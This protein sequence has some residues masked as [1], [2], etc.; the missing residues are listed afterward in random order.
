MGGVWL[1]A[2]WV[3]GWVD[4]RTGARSTG[5]ADWAGCLGLSL[6]S[7]CTY[8]PIDEHIAVLLCVVGWWVSGWWVGS[9]WLGGC[10]YVYR[11]YSS[12]DVPAWVA[13]CP[14]FAVLL[15]YQYVKRVVL[16]PLVLI[17]SSLLVRMMLKSGRPKIFV[18]D[19]HFEL[20]GSSP[21]GRTHS[22]FFLVC[23]LTS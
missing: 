18:D 13:G 15:I 16:M 23:S 1:G 3:G 5:V 14:C 12:S 11:V 19:H 22:F 20:M 6:L 2:E 10:T 17:G 21:S 4:G 7:L 8:S 9:R